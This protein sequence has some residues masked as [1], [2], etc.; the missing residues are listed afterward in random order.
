MIDG[1]LGVHP[2]NEG[3][4]LLAAATRIDLAEDARGARFEGG[5]QAS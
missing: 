2:V 4:E 1:H 3:D 5:E